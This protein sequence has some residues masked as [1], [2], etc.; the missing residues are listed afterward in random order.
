[1]S[2]S[3]LLPELQ[4]FKWA[5]RDAAIVFD[6]DIAEKEHVQAAERRAMNELTARGAIVRP[7]RLPAAETGGKVGL[8]DYLL[9]HDAD[10]LI[11]LIRSTAPARGSY[12]PPIA[13]AA[14]MANRYPRT[15]FAWT[16]FILAGETNLL[17]GD[18]GI[19]K[20]LLALHIAVAVASGKP[21]FG[22]D[23]MPMPVLGLFAED[24]EAQTQYRLESVLAS[25]GITAK[26]DLPIR[27]WCQPR[28]D[29]LLA[30]ID[31]N[32]TV[33]ELPRLHALRA[34]LA[35]IGRPALVILDSLADLFALNESLRLPVNAALKRVLG[36]LSRDF[37]ATV[38][39]LAH[40]SKT[41]MQDGSHYSGSTAFN[42]AVRQ[43]LTLERVKQDAGES[44]KGPRQCILR[45]AKS[46]YGPL[47]EKTLWFDGPSIYEYPAASG[48]D[49]CKVVLE[50]VLGWIAKGTR[51]VNRNGGQN[52]DARNLGDL[53][54]TIKEQHGVAMSAPR[55]KDHLRR[56][57]DADMLGYR[58]ANN[59]VRPHVKAGFVRGPKCKA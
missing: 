20:S 7:V 1:M 50:T 16:D 52:G 25:L 28:E 38:L 19:G 4:G 6:S 23:T 55:V 45:V 59:Q 2:K 10:H 34:E 8:D 14:L 26:A 22:Q 11:E 36:G 30:V 17:F 40:P 49:E 21:L 12:D 47:S 53:A 5:G 29:P 37:G 33:K 18:G 9:T 32:G 56:L 3:E 54:N 46:N 31:D 51:L 58:E 48:E 15:E 44:T 43:R 35:K 24:G 39:V 13:F 41:S 27:L 57:V 42:N